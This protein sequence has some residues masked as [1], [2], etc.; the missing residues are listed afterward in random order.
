MS[1]VL[2]LC[3]QS[4]GSGCLFTLWNSLCVIMIDHT[5]VEPHP[6]VALWR[7]VKKTLNENSISCKLKTRN[8]A[9][10]FPPVCV[11][12]CCKHAK[13]TLI[14]LDNKPPD[15]ILFGWLVLRR[16]FQQDFDVLS[17]LQNTKL[18]WSSSLILN[19]SYSVFPDYDLSK[20]KDFMDQQVDSYIEKG[21]IAK[22]E[23]D[24]IKRIYSSL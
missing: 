17:I 13:V 3:I 23:G 11:I 12:C 10:L 9:H 24:T 15:Y 18:S 16:H 19:R 2:L 22:D 7:W 21:I 1:S 4:K 8:L 20:L 6:A 5:A 14:R